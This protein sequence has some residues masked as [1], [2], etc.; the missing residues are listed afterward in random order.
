M[1][2]AGLKQLL[3]VVLQVDDLLSLAESYGVVEREGKLDVVGFLLALILNG[4]THEGGRQLDV[5]RQYLDQGY[6][7]VKRSTFYERFNLSVRGLL[8]EILQRAITAGQ[9]LPKLLPGILSSVVDWRIFDSTTVRLPRAS[10]DVFRG[11]GDYAAVKI[12]KVFSLGTGNLVSYKLTD[13][14]EHDS[15][16]LDVTSAL[17]GHG[18]VFDRGYVSL[19]RLASCDEHG[20][21]YVCRLKDGWKPLVTRLVRGTCA[22]PLGGDEDFDVLLQD[23][24]LLLDG[25]AIDADIVL[26]RGSTKVAARLVGVPTPKGYCF[27]LTNLSRATHGPLQVGEIYRCRWDIEVD[28]A[29]DKEG[30]RADEIGAS[31]EE[32]IRILILASMIA[33]TLS[34]TIV[35][36]EKL[37]I[38]K[39][40]KPT[41]PADRPPLHPIQLMK[42]MAAFYR[43]LAEK[44]LTPETSIFEWNRTMARLRLLSEDRKWRSHPSTLDQ[45]QGL[46]APPRPKRAKPS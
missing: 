13:A 6:K 27:F 46:T 45:I 41:E 5:L 16:H 20:V 33:A 26:G 37:A 28:N 3:T 36:S 14:A 25:K 39:D 24:V 44:L 43:S 40:K 29:V 31:N 11:T 7:P 17:S 30:A 42:S 22:E 32:P 9:A 12:H 38:R 15:K 19:A 23:D 10:R 8:E 21:S 35:Q 2:G 4:G 1:D 34:R 18:I